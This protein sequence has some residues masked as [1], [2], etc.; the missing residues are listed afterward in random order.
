MDI[1]DVSQRLDTEHLIQKR[2]QR[3]KATVNGST[4][5]CQE[6]NCI[7]GA[8]D[9]RLSGSAHP[10]RGRVLF[11]LCLF[12]FC[13]LTF[14]FALNPTYTRHKLPETP[15]DLIFQEKKFCLI[16]KQ[17]ISCRICADD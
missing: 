13:T 14:G 9:R 10:Q 4:G 1:S 8:A 12:L 2:A 16:V 3:Q 15:L 5:L 7:S 6:V 17:N 11:N